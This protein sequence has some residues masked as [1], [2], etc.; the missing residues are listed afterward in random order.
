MKKIQTISRWMMIL[1]NII[2]ILMPIKILLMSG[3]FNQ[4]FSAWLTTVGFRVD[5]IQ[6]P[7]GLLDLVHMQWTYTSRSVAILSAILE[8]TPLVLGVLFLKSIFKAYRAGKI[9]SAH[10]ARYYRRIG[11]L[12]E[13]DA[14]L[15]KPLSSMLMVLALTLSNPPGQ[16]LISITFTEFSFLEIFSGLIVMVIS[17]VMLEGLRLQEE[18]KLTV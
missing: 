18:Q 10:N 16:R 13:L 2:L 7:V 12:L 15:I 17:W 11:I 6:T 9:F 3:F 1:F 8:V 5:P 14:L 4:P